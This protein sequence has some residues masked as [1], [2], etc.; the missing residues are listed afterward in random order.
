MQLLLIHSHGF[1]WK[2]TEKAIKDAESS[3]EVNLYTFACA[4]PI[5]ASTLSLEWSLLSAGLAGKISPE[6]VL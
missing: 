1:D 5:I 3:K 4:F 6:L 2:V